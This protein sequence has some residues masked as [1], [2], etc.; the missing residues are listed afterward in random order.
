LPFLGLEG[1][2]ETPEELER[3]LQLDVLIGFSA[4]QLSHLPDLVTQPE[5]TVKN[6]FGNKIL[7][8]E[9]DAISVNTFVKT[10]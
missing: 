5:P 2:E 3:R 1:G 7:V 4:H 10:K 8:P 6:A 9:T